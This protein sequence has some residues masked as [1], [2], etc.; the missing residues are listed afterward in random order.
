M[1][2]AAHRRLNLFIY[3][4]VHIETSLK[5]E[6]TKLSNELLNKVTLKSSIFHF[7]A[8]SRLTIIFLP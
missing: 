5:S 7:Y 1:S 4:T 3:V 8:L 6:T 2:Y